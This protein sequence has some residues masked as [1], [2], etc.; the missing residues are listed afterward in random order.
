M[1]EELEAVTSYK[2]LKQEL[3]LKHSDD[4][5]SY[6]EGKKKFVDEILEKAKRS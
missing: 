1:R 5:K 3:E 6:T 2:Q 4:M